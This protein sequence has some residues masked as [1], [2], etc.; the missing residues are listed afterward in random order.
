M[1]IIQQFLDAEIDKHLG[2]ER[3]QRLDEDNNNYRNGYSSK[4]VKTSFGNVNIDIPRDRTV[5]LSQK[6]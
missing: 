1:V 2:I 5:N 4:T 3:Y 6:L